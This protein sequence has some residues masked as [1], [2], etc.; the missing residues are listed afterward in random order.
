[1]PRWTKTVMVKIKEIK[2]RPSR[3]LAILGSLKEWRK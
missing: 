1:M 3:M 2:P